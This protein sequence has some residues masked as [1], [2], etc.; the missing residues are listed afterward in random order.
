MNTIQSLSLP[1]F[2]SNINSIVSIYKDAEPIRLNKT[3]ELIE[4]LKLNSSWTENEFETFTHYEFHFDWLLMNSL[5]IAGFS[6][7]E[8]FMKGF[9]EYVE[10]TTINPIKLNDINGKGDID[11]Y[12]KY[13]HL[14]GGVSKAN[15]DSHEWKVILEFKEIRNAIV[16]KYGIIDKKISKA[17]Q[18]KI[19]YGQSEQMVRIKN[20]DFL[21]DFAKTSISYM[22]LLANDIS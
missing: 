20:I 21:E 16:H 5:F 17:V 14:I 13:I 3:K 1:L 11:R 4:K 10:K 7:F 9:A 8:N 18:H 22:E 6:Y 15:S 19:Y 2:S 12:R